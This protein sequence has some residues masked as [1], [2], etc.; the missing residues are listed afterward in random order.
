MAVSA[1]GVERVVTGFYKPKP[2]WLG[3]VP[4]NAPPQYQEG[5]KDG[6]ESGMAAY[7]N[8]Y[9]KTF[10]KIKSNSKLLSSPIYYNAWV[11]SFNYCRHYMNR[12]QLTGFWFGE[13]GGHAPE[14]GENEFSSGSLR[15]DDEMKQRGF[16]LPGMFDGVNSPG[17]GETGFGG[18]V[19]NKEDWLGRPKKDWLGRSPEYQ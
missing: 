10:Y 6:C 8:Y 11:D 9:Y 7:G 3:K 4:E 17:W 19:E 13:G 14:E 15:S 18:S 12:Y 1:C 5:W 16:S 2:L